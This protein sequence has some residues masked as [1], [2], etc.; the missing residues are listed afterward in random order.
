MSVAR[1][2]W[3]T[4]RCCADPYSR[5]MNAPGSCANGHRAGERER[6]SDTDEERERERQRDRETERQ[7]DRERER[8]R[9]RETERHGQA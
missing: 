7:R 4:G 9:D 6:D 1:P 2:P 5:A 8:E 3:R